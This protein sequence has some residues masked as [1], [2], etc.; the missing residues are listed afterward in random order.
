[1]TKAQ[2]SSRWQTGNYKQILDNFGQIFNQVNLSQLK[3]LADTFEGRIDCR[4]LPL[5]SATTDFTQIE[6]LLENIDFSY[7]ELGQPICFSC[8]QFSN[9]LFKNG[10]IDCSFW[11]SHMINCQ[12]IGGQIN[13]CFG[14]SFERKPAKK[15]Q[16]KAYY[17]IEKYGFESL[18][19][20]VFNKVTFKKYAGIGAIC[21]ACVF[22]NC[23]FNFFKMD[24]IFEDCQFIGKLRDMVFTGYQLELI[25]YPPIETTPFNSMKNVDFSQ[26][27]LSF[28][29]FRNGCD[30][31]QIIPPNSNKHLVINYTLAF[32]EKVEKLGLARG[33]NKH[34]MWYQLKGLFHVGL[35]K[36]DYLRRFPEDTEIVN[37]NQ[38]FDIHATTEP[39]G[40]ISVKDYGT[41][42]KKDEIQFA[43]DWFEICCIAKQSLVL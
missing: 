18:T 32:A 29:S 35:S 20:C 36:A 23:K 16:I 27:E 21:K 7:A 8:C 6:N 40:I 34:F 43:K 17:N 15:G 24:G 30:L 25:D 33:L 13:T 42:A 37:N 41:T 10:Q 12:F 2:L 39:W 14:T 26:C 28:M 9:C 11:G 5:P 22:E 38:Y 3:N 31:G 19:N 4:G 1:M